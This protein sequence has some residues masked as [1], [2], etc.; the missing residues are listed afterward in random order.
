MHLSVHSLAKEVCRKHRSGK[1]RTRASA[2]FNIGTQLALLEKR[3]NEAENESKER[4]R[5][6]RG[7]T[8]V[9]RTGE[10][11]LL[12]SFFGACTTVSHSRGAARGRSAVM[13]LHEHV[14]CEV[15]QK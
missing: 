13:K 6:I 10:A 5:W 14:N 1:E 2:K 4:D 11:F 7:A 12:S 9:R 8:G 15:K 3:R